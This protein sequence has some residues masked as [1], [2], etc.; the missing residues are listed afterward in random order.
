VDAGRTTLVGGISALAMT[1][2]KTV[3]MTVRLTVTMTLAGIICIT[4]VGGCGGDSGGGLATADGPYKIIAGAVDV[5]LPPSESMPLVFRLVDDQ[6]RGAPGRV[7][8]F[9]I[10][11]R[12][13]ARGATLSVDKA[14]TS[15]E[16]KVELQLIAGMVARFKL[17][18]SAAN[19]VPVTVQV[20]VDPQKHG[21]IEIIPTILASPETIR[22]V[23]Q[24]RLTFVNDAAC[25][26]V[27]RRLPVPNTFDP[28][29]LAP[30]ATTIFNSVRTEGNHAVVGQGLDAAG[31]VTVDG[32]VDLPGAA[33]KEETLMRLV[34]PLYPPVVSPVGRYRAVSELSPQGMLRSVATVAD[35]YAELSSCR[36]DPGR[37]WLDCTVDALQP[38]TAEDPLDCVPSAS[39]EM[40]FEGRLSALRGLPIRDPLRPKARCRESMDGAGRPSL[41]TQIEGMFAGQNPRLGENLKAIGIEVAAL[42]GKILLN[43]TMEL[44]ATSDPLRFQLQ[45]QMDQLLLHITNEPFPVDLLKLGLPLRTARFVAVTAQGSE[46]RIE[47]HGFTL[48]LGTAA[49]MAMQERILP[50][51]SYP[52]DIPEFITKL[53]GSAKRLDRGVNLMGCAAL[54]ALICPLVQGPEQCLMAACGSGVAALGKSLHDV[55]QVLDGRDLDLFLEGSTRIIERDGDGKADALGWLAPGSASAPGIWFPYI[56]GS[57]EQISFSGFFTADRLL[58]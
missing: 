7:L 57:D 33:V 20:I 14:V 16:G 55:F 17:R 43:S 30:G 4:A 5:A 44:T 2:T 36:S 54:S 15:S 3:R 32:C 6:D 40:A 48:R 52:G 46:L 45:H 37:L 49:R 53:F 23:S 31:M 25:M 39:D 18:V 35:R 28:R 38:E 12:A 22:T 56:L 26:T 21:P 29:T 41:E 58:P 47:R 27:N 9:E 34:L 51:R 24:V 11:D 10:P 19:A 42:F 13:A 50:R 8:E 1:L